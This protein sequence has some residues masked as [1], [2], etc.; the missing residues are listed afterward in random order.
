MYHACILKVFL[1]FFRPE[2]NVRPWERLSRDIISANQ[3]TPW[4]DRDRFAYWKGN[5]FVAGKRMELLKCNVS[6][7]HEWNARIYVQVYD[8]SYSC[9]LTYQKSKLKYPN[10]KN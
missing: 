9:S 2:T 3:R 10:F 7:E 5:P 1:P 8:I 6:A 4:K